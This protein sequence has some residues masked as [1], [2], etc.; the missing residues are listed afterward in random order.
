MRASMRATPLDGTRVLVAE[1]I[2]I[3]AYDLV[4][5]LRSAGVIVLG[6][7]A[8]VKQ[9]L[10]LLDSSEPHCGVLDVD[11]R[12]GCVFAAA[13][14]MRARGLGIVF[15][16]GYF[17]TEGLKREWPEALILTKPAS[18]RLLI[19]AVSVACARVPKLSTH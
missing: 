18:A 10:T 4:D 1:D 2:A 12:D 3:L 8:T 14:E 7:T 15:Y 13:E 11:L 19:K 9:A 6:P 16:T 17:D 5:I